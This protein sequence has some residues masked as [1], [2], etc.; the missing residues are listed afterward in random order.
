MLTGPTLRKTWKKAGKL[1]R[2]SKQISGLSSHTEHW[3]L[4][5]YPNSYD[6]GTNGRGVSPCGF[7]HTVCIGKTCY[8]WPSLSLTTVYMKANNNSSCWRH[9]INPHLSL[10]LSLTASPLPFLFI[11]L[12][13]LSL[14]SPFFTLPPSSF[15]PPTFLPLLL[16]SWSV[17]HP[18][19]L[20]L[21]PIATQLTQTITLHMLS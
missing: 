8:C 14:L 6:R 17:D 13:S 10:F 7:V 5:L 1:L 21:G 4:G 11:L 9:S 20:D 15:P 16:I 19:S 18:L 12:L 2:A 3:V